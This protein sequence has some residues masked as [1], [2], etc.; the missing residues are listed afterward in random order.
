MTAHKLPDDFNFDD[1]LEFPSTDGEP[2]AAPAPAAG[3]PLRAPADDEIGFSADTDFELFE[4]DA[5]DEIPQSSGFGATGFS[6]GGA[7]PVANTPV[8]ANEPSVPARSFEP[9]IDLAPDTDDLHGEGANEAAPAGALAG[10]PPAPQL[11]A[12]A[13]AAALAAP[14]PASPPSLQFTQPAPFNPVGEMIAHAEA[15]LGEVSVPRI[16]IHVFAERTDTAE[17]ARMAAND[18]R[19]SRA[20]TVVRLGGV[21]EA[22]EV[23]Q[24]ETTPALIIIEC[25][26]PGRHLLTELD[27]LAECCDSGT[28]VVVIGAANDIGLYRE[29]M[30]RGVSEYMVAPVQ[31]MQLIG[32]IGALY[33]DPSAPFVGRSIA[34]IGARGGVGSS[35]IAH[36]TAYALSTKL[37][38]ETVIVDFDLPFGTAGLDFN[39]DPLNGVA[40]ALSQP[41]RLDPVLLDRMMVKCG[42]R[43][44]LFAAPATLD[45]DWDIHPE[46]FEEVAQKIRTIA[47]F[48]VLD[49][50]H[51]W[52]AWV[53]RMMIG[54]DEVV[55][56]AS[57]DLASLRNAKNMIDLARAARPNDTPPRLV[58]NQAGVPG[59][60]EIPI[61]DF[62]NALNIQPALV[63][64]FDAKL[65]GQAANNGQMIMEVGAKSKAAEGFQHLAQILSNRDP[66]LALPAPKTE[67]KSLLGKLFKR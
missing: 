30:R 66:I 34:F 53:R 46:T 33:N 39:Q 35:T 65:F 13:A 55:V 18:R 38:S 1:D 5:D 48:V 22:M 62:A 64:P 50:P 40:D 51:Q 41:E 31:P 16:A 17:A 7:S 11:S 24:H 4:S 14:E 43:L 20:T 37:T 15:A 19:L 32:A 10:P 29:L 8:R 27:R 2:A 6:V 3:S 47:P 42:E 61:K 26:A 9:E 23:Y 52:N 59:R 12:P 28:K 49:L 54:A 67:S 60:P 57:P 45:N 56:V 63:L 36:N 21:A 25:G 44:S 58:V